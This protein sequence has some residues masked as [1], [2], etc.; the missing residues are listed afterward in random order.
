MGSSFDRSGPGTELLAH[1]TIQ[2][3][4]AAVDNLTNADGTVKETLC[5]S[6]WQMR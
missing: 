1:G 6:H 5:V 3:Q 4:V 2:E